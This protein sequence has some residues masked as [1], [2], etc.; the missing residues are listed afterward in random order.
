MSRWREKLSKKLFQQL[1]RATSLQH[2]FADYRKRLDR[3]GTV[4]RQNQLLLMMAWRTLAGPPP[5]WRDVEFR[6]FSQNGE[7]GILLYLF[8]RIGMESRHCVEIGCGSGIECNTANLILNHG[9]KGL[10][11]D[12]RE[13]RIALGRR[14]FAKCR[15]GPRPI[16]QLVHAWV[17]RGG[18]EDILRERGFKGPIDLLSIDLDG[19]DYWI[20]ETLACVEPRVVVIEYNSS[21][22]PDQAVTVAYADDF[23]GG[24]DL[25]ASLGALVKLGRR[26]GYRLVGCNSGRVNAFFVHDGVGDEAGPEADPA[27]FC[28]PTAR[29]LPP[30]WVEV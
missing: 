29:P 15:D 30:G 13:K 26:K 27:A 8:S 1:L 20:W 9:F 22:A 25:G 10:M 14:F 12:A 7:D 28:A 24:N 19:V 5:S 4:D 11:I 23:R 6:S 3:V 21:F 18:I 2:R 17:T 16:P